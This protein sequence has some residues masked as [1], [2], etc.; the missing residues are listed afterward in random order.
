MVTAA[1]AAMLM[2]A[3]LMVVIVAVAVTALVV[4]VVIV[5]VAIMLM[6]MVMVVMMAAA[7]MVMMD[8]HKKSSLWNFS[9]IIL[10]G[11]K[12]VKTFI[13]GEYPP[14]GVAKK[15]KMKYNDSI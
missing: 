6:V 1:A 2:V 8:V 5:A 7:G 15:G 11:F 12:T 4:M 14:C 3:A 9:F 13:F 10:E